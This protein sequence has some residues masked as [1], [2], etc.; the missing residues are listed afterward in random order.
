MLDFP[1]NVNASR[2]LSIASIVFGLAAAA[3]WFASA[4]GHMP[5]PTFD[6]FG[7][8]GRFLRALDDSARLNRWAAGYT[9]FSIL[10]SVVAQLF[11]KHRPA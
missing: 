8:N 2:I 6:D 5:V 11:E 7:P 3:L 1:T 10:F 4:W 9:G